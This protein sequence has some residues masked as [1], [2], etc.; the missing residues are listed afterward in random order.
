MWGHAML[1]VYVSSWSRE[2]RRQKDKREPQGVVCGCVEAERKEGE[3]E[4]ETKTAQ[5]RKREE[6]E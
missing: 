1:R 4:V 3:K 6:E 5:M 2:G